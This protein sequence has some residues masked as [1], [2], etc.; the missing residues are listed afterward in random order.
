MLRL[1]LLILAALA[2]GSPA[3]AS[4]PVPQKDIDLYRGIARQVQAGD[5]YYAAAVSTQ[6][7]SGYPVR[8]FYTVRQPTLSYVAA[9]LGERGL[10]ALA[11][12]TVMLGVL[13]WMRAIADRRRRLTMIALYAVA[14]GAM[15]SAATVY[16]TEVWCG[17][18]TAVALGW[19]DWRIRLALVLAACLMREFAILL[20]LCL[21]AEATLR[22][23]WIEASATAVVIAVAAVLLFLHATQVWKYT[24]PTDPVSQ[25]WFR[26][27][28][29]QGL[30][31]DLRAVTVFGILP[32]AAIYAAVAGALLG[33][34]RY[35]LVHLLWFGGFC[36]MVMIA[37]RP[38]NYYWVQVMMPLL[39]A[40][41]AFILG[42]SGPR[43]PQAAPAAPLTP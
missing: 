25:G 13:G 38:D 22:R 12:G 41:L 5:S 27:R 4:P 11:Y 31:S 18:L 43:P 3:L 8:P 29:P 32:M 7:A 36:L 42:A 23:R 24:L 6:R 20:L 9:T 21:L 37:S 34:A 26:L 15:I 40:G 33:W 28:G 17:L 10:I 14:S 39:P 1:C 19:R 16:F 35:S 30:V 2:L